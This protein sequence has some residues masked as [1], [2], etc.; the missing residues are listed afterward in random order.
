[1]NTLAAPLAVGWV[2]LWQPTIRATHVGCRVR[3]PMAA[4]QAGKPHSIL[5]AQDGKRCRGALGDEPSLSRA[6]DKSQQAKPIFVSFVPS[7]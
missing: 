4:P 3:Q 5:V 6:D 2:A 7:W 1:M